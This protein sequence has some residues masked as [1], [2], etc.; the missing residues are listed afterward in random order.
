MTELITAASKLP[1]FMAYPRFLLDSGLNLT[2]QQVYIILLDRA[3]LSAQNE[4]WTDENGHVFISYPIARLAAAI[5]K[6][7][8][9]VKTALSALEKAELITRQ[10]QGVG[11]ADRLY[12]RL[13][14]GDRKLSVT[15]KEN[16]PPEGQLSLL[17]T[18]RKL[19]TNK[20][21]SNNESVKRGSK[22]LQLGKYQN[23]VLLPEEITALRTGIPTLEQYIE[24]LS[25]YM[26]STG[27][28]YQSH[29]ATIRSW[30]LRDGAQRMPTPQ[31]RVYECR[32]DEGL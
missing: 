18:E 30:A 20:I 2:A 32:E 8:M 7:E 4:G 23:V 1:P 10:H 5:H 12:V 15:G 24:K 25:A 6:S 28:R 13:P 27:K 26:A 19:S 3:R 11:R 17:H 31:K 29:A 22:A 9:T 14:Q 21:K 16:F